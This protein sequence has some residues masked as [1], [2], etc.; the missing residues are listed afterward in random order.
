MKAEKAGENCR[1]AIRDRL[2]EL[3]HTQAVE[4]YG[5]YCLELLKFLIQ[6]ALAEFRTNNKWEDKTSTE[7][8]TGKG[9][10]NGW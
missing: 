2:L 7:K 9:I 8:V 5:W 10:L 1:F 6:A 3:G 4:L